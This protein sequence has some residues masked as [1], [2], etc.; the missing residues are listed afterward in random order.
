[1][2]TLDAALARLPEPAQGLARDFAGLFE[3]LD[4]W[5]GVVSISGS[6][7]KGTWVPSQS[8]IDF[9]VYLSHDIPPDEV[10]PRLVDPFEELADHWRAKGFLLDHI[11]PGSSLWMDEQIDRWLAGDLDAVQYVWT[12]W[13]YRPMPDVLNMVAVAGDVDIVERWRERAARYPDVVQ[14]AIYAR[15]RENLEYWP[16]DYHYRNK[17]GKEDIVFLHGVT[18]KLVNAIAEVLCARNRRWFTGDG[19][20]IRTLDGLEVKPARCTERIRAIL[21]PE[22]SPDLYARQREDLCALANETLALIDA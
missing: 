6:T 19:N 1:M 5:P 2:T 13:G 7:S 21:Y 8:D 14:Q 4:I 20:L 3:S 15:Y 10:G 9:R 17:V 11:G 12:M 18:D 22:P 16:Q